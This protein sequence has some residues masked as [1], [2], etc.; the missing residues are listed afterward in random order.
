MRKTL[1]PALLLACLVLPGCSAKTDVSYQQPQRYPFENT[2]VYDAGLEKVWSAAVA[3]VQGSFFVLDQLQKDARTM[4]LSFMTENPA[5]YVDCG[6]LTYT[7]AGGMGGGETVTVAGAAPVAKYMYGDGDSPPREVVRTATLAGKVTVVFSAE[8][9][10][11]TRAVVTVRYTVAIANTGDMPVTYGYS[12]GV[13]PFKTSSAV[14]FSGGQTGR[15]HGGGLT[16]CVSRSVVE[17]NILEGIQTA[18]G[19][20]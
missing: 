3:S 4:T 6:V 5:D 10:G 11:K 8:G 14:I 20:Q 19:A 15:M 17:K 12:E 18:L 1:F 16:Q 13:M 7:T 2:M 9:K